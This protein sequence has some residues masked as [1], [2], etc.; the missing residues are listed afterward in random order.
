[1]GPTSPLVISGLLAI[2]VAL[3]IGL[4]RVRWLAVKVLAGALALVLGMTSGLV[5]VNDYYGY[6]RTWGDLGRDL[7][8]AAPSGLVITSTRTAGKVRVRAGT[9]RTFDFAG[10]S[11][12]ISRPGFVYL[13]PQYDQPQYRHVRFPVLELLHGYPGKPSNWLYSLHVAAIV[14]RELALRRLGPMVLVMAP[15]SQGNAAQECLNSS[16]AQDETFLTTDVRTDITR[17]F[18]V[19]TDPAQWGLVGFSSG[20]YCATNL[21]LRNRAMFGSAASLDG[22]Y[23]A[24]DGPAARIL[25]NDPLLVA[26][27]SP[28]TEARGLAPGTAPIPSFWLSVGTGNADDIRQ[29]KSFLDALDPVARATLVTLAGQGHTFYAWQAALPTALTWS[30]Q[31][32]SPPD[33]RVQFPAGGS[34]A[35]LVVPPPPLKAHL[36]KEHPVRS[37]PITPETARSASPR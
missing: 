22:Y 8:N 12:G 11:S 36:P 23:Q 29:A 6:Y 25:N 35:Q 4:V 17:A 10:A 30:W 14:D 33:L 34:S 37:H 1:M 27:N 13:P 15:T 31:Q 7:S 26:A 16:R 5:L 32:L 18:R 9:V 19:S 2:A 20:G 21:A 3:L 28:V 24:G